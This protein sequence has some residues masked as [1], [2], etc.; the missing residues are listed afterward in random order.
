MSA[1]PPQAWPHR[2]AKHGGTR[3]NA[4]A[5]PDADM[6]LAVQTV[7][8]QALRDADQPC[9][10]GLRSWN[11]SDPAQRF[12]IY[13]NNIVVSLV[14]ALAEQ[15]PVTAELVGD[16]FFRAMARFFVQQ[17]PPR[18]RLIAF[19]GAHFA[20]FVSTFAPAS[21]VPYLSD[22]A[23]LE[24][25]RIH[26]CHAA[27][28]N[29]LTAQAIGAAMH[30]PERLA[31]LCFALHPSVQ[32][33][34]SSYAVFSL[35]AAHQGALDITQVDPDMA[36]QV[37][38]FRD[39]LDV[40]A[41]QISAGAWTFFT[42]LQVRAPLGHAASAAAEVDPRFDLAATVSLLLRHPLVTRM[43]PLP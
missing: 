19:A 18:T 13:R 29:P 12:A 5:P 36:Q 8:A 31:Q 40:Q 32:L 20:D 39:G 24:M 1:G 41:L 30:D 23:R 43:E 16:T 25:S 11:G 9:P 27:D 35:W 28:V 42:Q 17:H 14:D 38:V 37:L 3:L 33:L 22:V 2:S 4:A 15:F 7:F 21:A 34:A 26:A 6:H 10:G